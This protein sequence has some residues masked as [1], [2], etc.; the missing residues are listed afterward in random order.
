[1][2]ARLNRL[3]DVDCIK[4]TGAFYAFPDVSRTYERFG[5]AG[6]QAFCELVLE[7][8]HVALVPGAAFG[9]DTHVRLSFAN[10]MEHID[11]GLDSLATL[12]GTKT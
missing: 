8:A 6:S 12:L 11:K 10:S 3:R 9:I 2:H 5:V 4:P 7:Q 1:M